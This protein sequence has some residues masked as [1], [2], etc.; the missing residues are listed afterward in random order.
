MVVRLARQGGR[1]AV[2]GVPARIKEAAAGLDPEVTVVLSS[3]SSVRATG[4]VRE[5][6]PQADPV[7][8]TFAVR[9]G[10][11]QPPDAMRL[12]S[13]VTGSIQLGHASGLRI[14]ASALTTADGAAAVWVFDPGASTVAL[15]GVVVAESGLAEVI[16]AEGLAAGDVVVTAGV[17][18]LRPGQQVRL[19]ETAP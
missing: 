1:D 13:T 4:R 9:V 3:D 6:S 19:L 15:R 5:V 8:R 14:P 2:F 17:Q 7:T 10:L 12:G 16:I 11:S 18:T